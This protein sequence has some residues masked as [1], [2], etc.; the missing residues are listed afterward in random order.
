MMFDDNHYIKIL[1]RNSEKALEEKLRRSSDGEAFELVEQA[2]N[3]FIDDNI[4]RPNIQEHHLSPFTASSLSASSSPQPERRKVSVE[5]EQFA[6]EISDRDSDSDDDK[7]PYAPECLQ[8][9]HPE[10]VYFVQNGMVYER[11][12]LNCPSEDAPFIPTTPTCV[13]LNLRVAPMLSSEDEDE[14]VGSGINPL[15]LTAD[16]PTRLTSP[17]PDLRPMRFTSRPRAP[18]RRLDTVKDLLDDDED[19]DDDRDPTDDEYCPSPPLPARKK[20]RA[21]G[22]A[23]RAASRGK[24][25]PRS[26]SSKP[27]RVM[28]QSRNSQSTSPAFLKVVNKKRVRSCDFICPECGFEQEN[29]RMPDYQRHLRTH[30][31]PSDEDQSRGWWCKG[32]PVEER[33]NYAIPAEAKTYYFQDRQRIGGCRLTFSRRDALKRHLDNPN[34]SCVGS[35]SLANDD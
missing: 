22:H 1:R 15:Y 23:R 13:A 7:D 33:Y 26:T 17:S 2:M 31:R 8:R 3:A 34:V 28:P 12:M 19:K 29:K 25:A 30:A 20:T 5:P 18:K 32:V 10:Q 27:T 24:R 35:P 14:E 4:V 11:S 16:S 6:K 9:Y 21:S